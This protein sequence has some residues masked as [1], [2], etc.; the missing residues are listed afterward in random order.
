[1]NCRVFS[2]VLALTVMSATAY[3]SNIRTDYDHNVNFS[4]YKTF[5]WGKV[6]T[7]NKKLPTGDKH[8]S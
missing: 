5:S 1:M 2:G 8:A 4:H 7:S 3:A 6:A